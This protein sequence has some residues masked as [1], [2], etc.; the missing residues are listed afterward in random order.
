MRKLNKS[1]YIRLPIIAFVGFVITLFFYCPS[2]IIFLPKSKPSIKVLPI[3]IIKERTFYKFDADFD[4]TNKSFRKGSVDTFEI[5]PLHIPK[6]DFK[7]ISSSLDKNT[8]R[9]KRSQN[10]HFTV[11]F[12][13]NILYKK[14]G[15]EETEPLV[16]RFFANDGSQ[17]MDDK[18]KIA[19][20]IFGY[21]MSK[22]PL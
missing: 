13:E 17:I 14:N 4:F 3:K 16:L 8:I 18:G 22:K 9:W 2:N 19:F 1:Q 20:V 7:I 15:I 12:E 5:Y 6:S 10:I 21:Q 11:T